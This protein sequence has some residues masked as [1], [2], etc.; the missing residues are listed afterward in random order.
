MPQKE[1][2]DPCLQGWGQSFADQKEAAPCPL[3]DSIKSPLSFI[4]GIVEIRRVH[5][6]ATQNV[7]QNTI[8]YQQVNMF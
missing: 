1:R 8:H 6:Y 7:K 3:R 4:I 2:C 5:I